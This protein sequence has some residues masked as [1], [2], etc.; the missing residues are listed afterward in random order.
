LAFS[1]RVEALWK[2]SERE[3]LCGSEATLALP[4]AEMLANGSGRQVANCIIIGFTT[5]LMPESRSRAAGFLKP[6]K[7]SPMLKVNMGI[8]EALSAL[9]HFRYQP[10]VRI[11]T[12]GTYRPSI[13]SA[14][15]A[16]KFYHTSRS[17]D[18]CAGRSGLSLRHS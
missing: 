17:N 11:L 3:T 14:R 1:Q 9:R 10:K 18:G 6:R 8:G 16:V 4:A 12:T 15:A 5:L 13:G 2:Q 7:L